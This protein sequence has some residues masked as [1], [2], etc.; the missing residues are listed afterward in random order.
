[1]GNGVARTCSLH[2]LHLKN[3]C[4][5]PRQNSD[6]INRLLKSGNMSSMSSGTLELA[7]CCGHVAHDGDAEFGGHGWPNGLEQPKL[8]SSGIRAKDLHFL[9]HLGSWHGRRP[10]TTPVSSPSRPPGGVQSIGKPS[11]TGRSVSYGRLGSTRNI[12][13]FSSSPPSAPPA[14]RAVA[15]ATVACSRNT[16]SFRGGG[17]S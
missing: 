7:M 4:V 10:N 13:A 2:R 5:T 1:M 8:R 15:V 14:G 9:T 3:Y 17:V 6:N 11:G 16:S 12:D